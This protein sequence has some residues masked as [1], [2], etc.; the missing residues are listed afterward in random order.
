MNLHPW[1]ERA[2]KWFVGDAAPLRRLYPLYEAMEGFFFVLSKRTPNAPLVRDA[3]DIKRYMIAVVVALAP[4]YLFGLVAFG[5]RLLLMTAVSYAVGGLVE[6][7]FAIFRKEDINE[8]FLVTGLLFP[9]ILPPNTP[10]WI[11][12]IG[13]AFGVFFGKEVFGGT[14]HNIFNPALVGRCFVALSWPAHLSRAYAAPLEWIE[15]FKN[16]GLMSFVTGPVDAVTSATPLNIIGT[17]VR[18]G[19]PPEF[20][21]SFT[22]KLFAGWT[23]GSFCETS[24]ILIILT[25]AFLCWTKVSSWRTTASVIAGYLVVGGILSVVWPMRFV[26]PMV[27]IAAGGILFAAFY[28]A[29]DP[30][31]SPVSNRGKIIYGCGIGALTVLFRGLGAVPEGVTYAVLMM[32]MVAP[33]LDRH[34]ILRSIPA[35]L[36]RKE[37]V[38]EGN[39]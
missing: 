34:F 12:A 13:I 11:I 27:G 7:L 33:L 8:G 31:T 28:M 37:A 17:A 5:P 25:G 26:S 3:V 15:T 38:R 23:N 2:G 1:F 39:A 9:M 10:L 16:Q 6:T 18:S 14:G 35:K 20:L 22:F 4:L 36:P 21:S 19:Q 32:N 24:S 30:V 29:T